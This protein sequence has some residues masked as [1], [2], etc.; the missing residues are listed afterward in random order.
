M[1]RFV[2]LHLL[3]LNKDAYA[4]IC[5]ITSPLFKQ[6]CLCTDLLDYISAPSPYSPW[7]LEL[8]LLQ[9]SMLLS[10]I[11]S[12]R[13]QLLVLAKIGPDMNLQH[14]RVLSLAGQLKAGMS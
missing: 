9:M 4:Q 3:Y 12:H 14:P 1:H 13:P 7:C 2:G 11:S 10:S 6:G 5:W 8:S